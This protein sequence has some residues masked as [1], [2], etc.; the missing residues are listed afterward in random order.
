[1]KLSCI[2]T[3]YNEGAL[4]Q[5][6]LT[7]LLAQTYEDFEVIVVDDGASEA[8]R[9]ALAEFSDPR[10]R[11]IRQ[12]NDGLSSARNRAIEHVTG[13]YVC[14]LDADDQRPDWAFRAIT[15]QIEQY[16]PD[17]ILCTGLYVGHRGQV[18]PF[19]DQR[20][21]E[22]LAK[23]VPNDV[24]AREDALWNQAMFY[25]LLTEPQSAN[26]FIRTG[27]LRDSS[28]RFPNGLVFED[29]FFHSSI[30]AAS[31]KIAYQHNPA[32]LYYHR[33]QHQQLTGQGQET[34]FDVLATV[35]MTCE[36][37]AISPGFQDP[38]QRTALILAAMR[39]IRWS[40]DKT[41]HS[42]KPAFRHA[43][44]GL[45]KLID[46]KYLELVP[47][48]LSDD[49]NIRNLTAFTKNLMNTGVASVGENHLITPPQ[50]EWKPP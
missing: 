1:M 10:I 16:K 18:Q 35:K 45:F 20:Y 5:E 29:I 4:L 44:A 15:K 8:S 6:S 33:Y 22:Q 23:I 13:D 40:D 49:N 43:A 21:F 2:T 7:S 39:I 19:F 34:R 48:P 37:F 25:S 28:I 11:V 47:H 32:F 46:Q 14:F 17:L 38:K 27:L 30:I 36:A 41:A 9:Q 31:D 12:A 50:S 26:K 42:L 24:I 3:I